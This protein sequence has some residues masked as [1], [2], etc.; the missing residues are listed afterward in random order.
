MP[1][2]TVIKPV[3]GLRVI[4]PTAGGVVIVPTVIVAFGVAPVMTTGLPLVV[5]LAVTG[6]VVTPPVAG[7]G[8]ALKLPAGSIIA[9]MLALTVTVSVIKA[10]LGVGVALS[11]SL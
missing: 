3:D 5:S 6:V 9:V 1:G 8:A 11:H 2:A 4:E 10:Q 7:T